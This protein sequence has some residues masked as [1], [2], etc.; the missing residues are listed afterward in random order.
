[1][2]WDIA[3]YAAALGLLAVAGAI[4]AAVFRLFGMLRRWDRMA[5]RL[6]NKADEAVDEYTR[7]AQEVRDMAELCR[8]TVSGFAR[9]AEGARAVG[10]A[11]ETAAQAAANAASYWH[12]RLTFRRS[13]ERDGGMPGE[14]AEGMAGIVRYLRQ[15][16]RARKPAEPFGEDDY[17][18]ASADPHS[19]E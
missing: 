3:A 12:D 5:L 11:A 9:L 17:P 4:S 7:L 14:P 18:G 6:A 10:E 1:M 19:G 16:L 2:A 8:Q 13:A 15:V